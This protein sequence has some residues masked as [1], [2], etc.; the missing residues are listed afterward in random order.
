M[1]CVN[2][3]T[4][5]RRPPLSSNLLARSLKAKQRSHKAKSIGSSPIGQTTLVGD[6]YDSLNASVAQL[7]EQKILNLF[8]VGSNPT[9]G[10]TL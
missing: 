2:G 3:H 1:V 4:F 8:V 7:A 5:T 10:T 6:A 9:R